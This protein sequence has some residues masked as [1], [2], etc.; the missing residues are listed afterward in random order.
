MEEEIVVECSNCCSETNLVFIGKRTYCSS[1]ID[2]MVA[3]GLL[4][5]KV[6]ENER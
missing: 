2:E 4:I 1:C 3:K 5:K 6:K